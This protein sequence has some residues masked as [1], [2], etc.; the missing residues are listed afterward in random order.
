MCTVETNRVSYFHG[1]FDATKTLSADQILR[2]PLLISFID[3]MGTTARDFRAFDQYCTGN[4]SGIQFGLAVDDNIHDLSVF[5]VGISF[6]AYCLEPQI[7][8]M[9]DIIAELL[10]SFSF[11]DATRFDMLLQNYASSLSVGIANSGHIYA[12]QGAAGL[13]NEAGRLKSQL[14]GI[15]HIEFVRQ[16]QQRS[17]A[18]DIMNELAEIA[19]ILFSQGP[20]KCALN[21]SEPLRDRFLEEYTRFIGCL[22]TT[23]AAPTDDWLP[24]KLLPSSNVHNVMNIPVNYCAKSLPT[25]PYAHADYAALRVLGKVLSSKYLLPIVRE[26][27]GAYGAGAKIAKDGVFSFFS[28]RDPNTDKTLDTFD[29]SAKWIHDNWTKLDDQLLFESKLGVLQQIDDPTAPGSMG[30]QYFQ[31]GIDQEMHEEHRKGVLRVSRDD[32]GRV[33]D[34]YLKDGAVKTV[35]RF[36]LGP[37]NEKLTG[38]GQWTVKQF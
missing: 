33:T 24:S 2:L 16:L 6:S 8:R 32:L 17:S 12:M 3:Q 22:K 14:G 7:G 28:Y 19:R 15:E 26:Q 23:A 11:N 27:N 38:D 10:Q 21:T 31:H 36:V 18:A 37:A 29:G 20:L 4:T 25:V 13:V 34:A 1:M 35:G 30:L 9:F 5:Q